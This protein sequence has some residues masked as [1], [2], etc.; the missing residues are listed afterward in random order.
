[1]YFSLPLGVIYFSPDMSHACATSSLPFLNC[2]PRYITEPISLLCNINLAEN[3]F[4]RHIFFQKAS[5]LALKTALRIFISKIGSATAVNDS[6]GR[7]LFMLYLKG[8][9]RSTFEK[10]KKNAASRNNSFSSI[11]SRMNL[12]IKFTLF[13]YI[14][15]NRLI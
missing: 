14:V 3:D 13:N 6:E 12:R 5:L 4:T 11:G 1:L 15:L 2:N 9:I 8:S 10:Y 7:I